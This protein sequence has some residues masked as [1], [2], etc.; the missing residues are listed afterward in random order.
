[1]STTRTLESFPSLRPLLSLRL[2]LFLSP[3]GLLLAPSLLFSTSILSSPAT[4]CREAS[5][6][7]IRPLVA[8]TLQDGSRRLATLCFSTLLSGSLLLRRSQSHPLRHSTVPLAL[9]VFSSLRP[10]SL[11]PEHPP[12]VSLSSG[13][14]LAG[15]IRFN[16]RKGKAVGRFVGRKRR[17]WPRR[18]ASLSSYVTEEGHCLRM[19]RLSPRFSAEQP[20]LFY[21]CH[22]LSLPRYNPPIHLPTFSQSHN[23]CFFDVVARNVEKEV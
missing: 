15:V 23:T 12:R 19:S 11:L 2:L 9:F 17:R 21:H 7:F 18:V 14:V 1:M 4:L 16:E 8:A 5:I 22:T 20:P 3:R 10:P 13:W 6:K